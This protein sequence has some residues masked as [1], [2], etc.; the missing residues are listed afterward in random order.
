MHGQVRHTEKAMPE[1]AMM[2]GTVII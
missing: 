1:M 2:A